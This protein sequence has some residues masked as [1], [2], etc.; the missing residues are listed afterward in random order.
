MEKERLYFIGG[1]MKHRILAL[2]LSIIVSLTNVTPAMAEALGDAVVVESEDVI[3]ETEVEE[4]VVEDS[5]EDDVYYEEVQV[6]ENQVEESNEEEI[7]EAVTD[8]VVDDCMIEDIMEVTDDLESTVI[9]FDSSGYHDSYGEQLPNALAIEIYNGFIDNF[10]LK[11]SANAFTLNLNTPITFSAEVKN[12]KIV[13]NSAYQ[14]TVTNISTATQMAFDAFSYDYPE[15]FWLKKVSVNYR[16]T[17]SWTSGKGWTAK[18][19]S[20]VMT[21]SEAYANA[22]SNIA[23]FDNATLKVIDTMNKALGS[24]ASNYA[25]LKYIH[26]YVCKTAYYKTTASG[27]DIY[28]AGPVFTGKAGVVCEGY[29]KSFKVLCDLVGIE[30][31]C[32]SGKAV[33]SCGERKKHMWNYVKMEDGAWY[34]VDCTW[35]DQGSR[36]LDTY[37]LTGL[38]S[39]GFVTTNEKERTENGDF[40]ATGLLVFNYP[41]LSNTTYIYTGENNDE[42]TESKLL[43]SCT[44]EEIEKQVASGKAVT[45]KVVIRYGKYVL[46]EGKDYTL[47]YLNNVNAGTATINITGLGSYTGEVKATFKIICANPKLTSVYNAASGIGVKWNVVPGAAKYCVFRKNGKSS[48]KKIAVVSKNSYIDTTVKSGTTYYY[49]VR[50]MNDEETACT[51]SYD[52]TGKGIKYVQQPKISS[53][54]NGSTGINLKWNKISTASGYYVYRGTSSGNL[55]KIATIKKNSTI[56]YS[57]TSVKS[58][59][60]KTYVYAIRSY[61]GNTQSSIADTKSINRL[62]QPSLSSVNNTQTGIAFKW[63]KV[64][65]ADGYHVYRKTTGSWTKIATITSS[66]TVGYLDKNSLKSGTTYKYTVRA[67]KGSSLS[68]YNT[69]GLS[70]KRLTQPSLTSA[71]NSSK[72]ITVKWSKVAGASG[73]YVYRKLENGSYKK[74]ATVKGS[75]SVSYYDKST[76]LKSRKNYTYTVKAY[77][78]NSTS[79]CLSAGKTVKKK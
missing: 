77:N 51:S 26:D 23:N 78:G 44:I 69:T 11:Q 53:C 74:I 54:L 17:A 32:V 16:I 20:L 35:D 15:V 7:K 5:L 8:I 40:S 75:S 22:S 25:K 34:L 39:K 50:C 66:D 10:Q 9:A 33:N 31:V 38:T 13:S 1:N 2:A 62:T 48:W 41:M 6:E 65:G 76:S 42:T 24:D 29:A 70:I 47:Q 52:K 30:S 43:S 37:F 61:S 60:G 27:S 73:Y 64:T 58:N 72:G 55:K 57:D 79:S 63:K 19:S 59:S 49:T 71:Y 67:Y 14:K 3:E 21:P 28:S 56:N 4:S 68:S 36:I 45:P 46:V 12:D 18:I